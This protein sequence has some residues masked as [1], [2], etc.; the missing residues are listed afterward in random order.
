MLFVQPREVVFGG[1]KWD[2]VTAVTV[3][4]VATRV[5]REWDDTGPHLRF[6]DVP[7]RMVTVR[8][9]QQLS[10]GDLSA[11]GVGNESV[12]T[13]VTAPTASDVGRRRVTVTGVVTGVTHALSA[14]AGTQGRFGQSGMNATRTIT[15]V[16]TS[17]NGGLDP[18]VITNE[19][20]LQ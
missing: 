8:V 19:G 4:R 10:R 7:D 14:A 5:V 1:Q 13:F 16:A 3:D 17:S 2:D 15:I 20:V 6:V 12:L 9:V 18:V 11:P